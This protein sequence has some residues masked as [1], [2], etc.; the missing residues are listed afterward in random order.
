MLINR[1]DVVNTTTFEKLTLEKW[2][3]TL[4]IDLISVDQISGSPFLSESR[5]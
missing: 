1:P 5:L 4:V 3:Q 2:S